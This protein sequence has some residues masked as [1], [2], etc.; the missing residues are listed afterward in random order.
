[1]KILGIE[2]SGQ[3]ASVAIMEDDKLLGEYTINYKKTH[4]ETLLPMIDEVIKMTETKV[5]ELDAIAVS[6]GP[7]SFTGLRIGS[8]TAKGFALA[9][10]IPI[11]P[12]ATVDALAYHLW[13]SKRLICPM[14][15]ARRRQVYTG[16][17]HFE[18]ESLI[19]EEETNLCMIEDVVEK[20]NAA[21]RPVVL[22]GDAA[23]NFKD[24]LEENLKTDYCFAPANRREQS[25]ACVAALG[26]VLM[27]E[28][29]VESGEE[30]KP[31]YL[32][33]SQAERE[34]GDKAKDFRI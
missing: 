12:V 32:R 5:E 16:L 7:G 22:L 21:N 29:K 4:S 26:M 23:N 6:K 15:D 18:G 24:Y 34:L 8:A 2:A 28:G 13:G 9:L 11:I 3:V 1:M 19:V 33:P 14:M 25:A 27:K 31:D 20:L 10:N 30:H 17:Y